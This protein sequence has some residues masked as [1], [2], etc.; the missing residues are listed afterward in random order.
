MRMFREARGSVYICS[1]VVSARSHF[2]LQERALAVALPPS[3][4][5]CGCLLVRLGISQQ[6]A[7]SYL[8]NK[9]Q[10]WFCC[11]G[12]LELFKS[13]PEQNYCLRHQH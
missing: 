11:D 3:C 8:Y 5:A 10:Y 7:V 12:C 1:P 9:K 2:N 6:K 4:S 13:G